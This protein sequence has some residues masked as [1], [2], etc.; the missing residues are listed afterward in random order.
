MS[1]RSDGDGR[2]SR[3]TKLKL[4]EL[5]TLALRSQLGGL[6]A[7]T[8]HNARGLILLDWHANADL[9]VVRIAIETHKK[10]KIKTLFNLRHISHLLPALTSAPESQR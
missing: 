1:P 6:Q 4:P 7:N 8:R 10:V 2:N 3:R 9:K 5:G